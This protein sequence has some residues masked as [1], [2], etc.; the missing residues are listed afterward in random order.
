MTFEFESQSF[1]QFLLTG[2]AEI[3][4]QSRLA[5]KIPDPIDG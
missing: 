5:S 2:A 3:P 1:P 4:Q